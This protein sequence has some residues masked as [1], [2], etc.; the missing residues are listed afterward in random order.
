MKKNLKIKNSSKIFEL[1][2]ENKIFI[3][4]F[5]LISLEHNLQNE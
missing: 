2:N 3:F 1:L 4:F 5:E